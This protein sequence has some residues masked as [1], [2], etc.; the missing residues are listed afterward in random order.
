M[1]G[2]LEIITMRVVTLEHVVYV[3]LKKKKNTYDF[4]CLDKDAMNQLP[5][6]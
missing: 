1:H 3:D 4:K 5:E 2:Q 6:D